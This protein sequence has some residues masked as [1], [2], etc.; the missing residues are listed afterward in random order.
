MNKLRGAAMFEN[1]LV[2]VDGRQGGRDAIALAIRL[3]VPGARTALAH[4]DP[5]ENHP[6]RSDRR[7]DSRKML[8]EE[9]ARAGIDAKLLTLHGSSTAQALHQLAASRHYDL[10]V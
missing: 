5:I 2:G 7:P 1:V 10:L 3:A 6:G 4:V 9:R 8:T